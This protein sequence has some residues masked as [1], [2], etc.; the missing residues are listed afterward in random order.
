M[1]VTKA[2]LVLEIDGVPHFAILKNVNLNL[3]VE[4]IALLIESGKLDVIKAPD[5]YQ[6]EKIEFK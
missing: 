5:K 4:M 6:F 3:M 2:S 1:N